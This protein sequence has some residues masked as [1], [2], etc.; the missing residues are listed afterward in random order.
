M[1]SDA[2]LDR[3]HR[4]LLRLHQELDLTCRRDRDALFVSGWNC[5]TPFAHDFLPAQVEAPGGMARYHFMSDDSEL[6]GLVRRYHAQRDGA[7]LSEDAVFPASGSSLL[8]LSQFLFL[9]A[10][11]VPTV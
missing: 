10:R 2:E 11:R 4:E 9:L 5:V 1:T 3:R 7:D 6:I 8:I